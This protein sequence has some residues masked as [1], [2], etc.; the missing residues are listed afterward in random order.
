MTSEVMDSGF[1]V[2][3]NSRASDPDG[4]SR[5]SRQDRQIRNPTV[6]IERLSL[7]A[8]AKIRAPEKMGCH[9]AEL[10]GSLSQV[11]HESA[12]VVVCRE[13]TLNAE[14]LKSSI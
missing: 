8:E 11:I 9:G 5:N 3:K 7:V 2:S 13:K 1:P 14:F 12:S 4:S 6:Q 10:R